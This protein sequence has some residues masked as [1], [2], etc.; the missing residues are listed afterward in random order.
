VLIGLGGRYVHYRAEIAG[1][2][3]ALT[4]AGSA[5]R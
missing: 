5:A 3:A 1:T 4:G 2:I